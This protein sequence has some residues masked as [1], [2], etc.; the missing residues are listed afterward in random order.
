[1]SSGTVLGESNRESFQNKPFTFQLS[2]HNVMTPQQ[3]QATAKDNSGNN[4]PVLS[5]PSKFGE[6][7]IWDVTLTPTKP[8]D[9][10]VDVVV[11][12]KPVKGAPV[13]LKGIIVFE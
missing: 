13:I 7:K 8:G 12:K 9:V 5:S 10:V 6:N 2:T 1:L 11:G 3:I 4:Y